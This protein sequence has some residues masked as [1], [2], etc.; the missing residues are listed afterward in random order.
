M[1]ELSER[2]VDVEV[3]TQDTDTTALQATESV[4]IGT[5]MGP[6]LQKALGADPEADESTSD[7]GEKVESG[8][9]E[10]ARKINLNSATSEELQTIPGIGPSLA[11]R[12]LRYREEAEAFLSKDELLAIPGIGPVLYDQI[13]EWLTV[14]PPG[15]AVG[16]EAALEESMAL[17]EAQGPRAAAE[18]Q[19]P[20]SQPAPRATA[21]QPQED[22]GRSW[23]WLWSALLGGILGIAGTLIILAALNG[24]LTLGQTPVVL[25]INSRLEGLRMDLDAVGSEL[26]DAQRRLAQLEG[27]PARMD[28]VEETVTQ[29]S[30]TVRDLSDRVGDL[31]QTV[32]TLVQRTDVLAGRVDATEENIDTL[33]TRADRVD[34][35][36]GQLQSL[37][38]EV[39]G[40][41]SGPSE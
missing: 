17:D 34:G 36:F 3:E 5:D 12:I 22:R 19:R 13:S 32:D 2:Q 24:A 33:T 41:G 37:L 30:S 18:P 29:L 39:F 8:S 7:G 16:F 28:D 23:A 4:A 40:A 25:D 15:A 27:L 21:P 31:Q 10:P 11:Q 20:A 38:T 9:S 35:F 14:V 1:D 26:T 6:A